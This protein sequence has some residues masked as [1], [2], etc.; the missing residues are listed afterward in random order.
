MI[1]QLTKKLMK[2]L[3]LNLKIKITIYNKKI[4]IK[5]KL[6]QILLHHY[7]ILTTAVKIKLLL[8]FLKIVTDLNNKKQ[9]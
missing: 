2:C 7:I 5:I 8:S 4:I 1:L 9:I 3:L 6:L